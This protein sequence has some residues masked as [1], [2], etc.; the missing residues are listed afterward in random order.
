MASFNKIILLGNLTRDPELRV[1]A[2]GASICKFGMA[3]SRTFSAQDGTRREET[4][5][6]DVDAFGRP[7]EIISK[8]MAKGRPIMVEGR[9]RLDQWESQTGEK[10]SK[11]TVVLESFQFVGG[12]QDGDNQV[13]GASPYEAKAPAQRAAANASTMGDI[14]EDVPF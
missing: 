7:A 4:L 8:Y 12:R 14:D 3:C 1:T 10:R 2:N 5:F 11:H 13:D 6:V 9:L